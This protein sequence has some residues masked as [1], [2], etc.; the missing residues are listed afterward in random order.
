[1]NTSYLIIDDLVNVLA[2][3]I[4]DSDALKI[5]FSSL[6]NIVDSVAN[7][8]WNKKKLLKLTTHTTETGKYEHKIRK[9]KTEIKTTNLE[10]CDISEQ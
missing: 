8:F 7:S 10:R 3:G 6:F 4:F 9:H 5:A 2:H 1:M